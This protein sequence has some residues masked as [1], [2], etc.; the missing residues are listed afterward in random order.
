V[1]DGDG[2]TDA[3]SVDIAVTN[4]PPTAQIANP[5]VGVVG[6][7]LTLDGS[8]SVDPDGTIVDWEWDLDD[9]GV[10]ETDGG[11]G[12]TLDH[13][14]TSAGTPTVRLRVT[15]SDG[16][17]ATTSVTFTVTN[18]PVALLSATPNPARPAQTVSL[19]AS[20]S[21][22]P[23]GTAVSFAWDLDGDGT[24]ETDTG[25]VAMQTKSWAQPGNHTVRVRVTDEDGVST[26][27]SK[28]VAVVNELPVPSLV[29]A[30]GDAVAGTP[31]TL[32]ASGSGDPD[33]TIVRYQWDL[34]G[35]GSFETD[36]GTTAST[37]RTY[38]NPATITVKLRVTDNDG[39]IATTTLT[40]VVK[41][42]ATGPT[43]GTG[44]TGA[45]GGTG[46]TAGTGG[47]G[48]AG[49]AGGTGEQ[50]LGDFSAGLGGAPIQAMKLAA[51]RGL[52]MTCSSDRA[53]RCSVSASIDSRTARKLRLARKRRAAIVGR[54]VVNVPSG[55]EGRFVLKLSRKA[56]RALRRAKRVRLLVKGT[57]IDADG[58]VVTLARTVL[59]RR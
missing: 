8:G 2:T 46:G 55:G 13:V 53:L 37:V 12:A 54:A 51:R 5:G 38:A 14:F 36:T 48:A 45:T 19:D 7:S 15:D 40:V 42:P 56:R 11:S 23:D 3:T 31:V 29:V 16:A 32:D 1:T 30:G 22:D 26:V 57:A 27:A 10:Y 18:A 25:A 20:G 47:T 59:L 43:G 21:S 9:D 39:G 17:S 4:R 58:H 50:P 49:G 6:R 52:T 44:G 33:G 34:D 41:A 24:F 35:N 28:V